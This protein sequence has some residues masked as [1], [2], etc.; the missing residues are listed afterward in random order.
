M[1]IFILVILYRNAEFIRLSEERQCREISG[2][3]YHI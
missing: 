1:Q 2:G 3:P